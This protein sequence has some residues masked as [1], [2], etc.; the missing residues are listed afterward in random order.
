MIGG[1]NLSKL[2]VRQ[3]V[4][5]PIWP[6]FKNLPSTNTTPITDAWSVVDCQ[7]LRNNS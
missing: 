6:A 3:A 5:T 4:P 1:R 2:E 7:F